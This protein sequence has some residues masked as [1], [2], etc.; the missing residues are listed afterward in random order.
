[1]SNDIECKL[2]QMSKQ[3]ITKKKSLEFIAFQRRVGINNGE[4][5]ATFRFALSMGRDA[6]RTYTVCM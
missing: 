1:M 3:T 5:P 6:I 2:H 4:A